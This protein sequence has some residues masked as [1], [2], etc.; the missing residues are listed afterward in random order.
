ML[1]ESKKHEKELMKKLQERLWELQE[2]LY[3]EHKHNCGDA[4]QTEH[5]ISAGRSETN[6]LVVNWNFLQ[7][8]RRLHQKFFLGYFLLSC[9]I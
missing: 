4:P 1:A 2:L 7:L 8:Y 9:I 3:A 6:Y 5:E